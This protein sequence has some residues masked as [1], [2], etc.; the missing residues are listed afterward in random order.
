MP[1][2]LL[3]GFDLSRVGMFGH[4]LGGATTAAA[5]HRDPRIKAGINLDG[6]LIGPL[7]TAGLDRPFLLISAAD[8]PNDPTWTTLWTRLR[9]WKRELLLAGTAHNSFGDLQVFF[10]QQPLGLDPEQIPLVIGTINARR[11]VLAQRTYIRTF[12]DQHLLGRPSPQ[13]A[14]PSPSWPEVQFVR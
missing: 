7:S 10:G 9:Q 4:S 11:S 8:H 14:G 13:L 1:D 6:R 12:F 3:N 2:G 5:M